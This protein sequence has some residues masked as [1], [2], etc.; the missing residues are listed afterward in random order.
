MS[1]SPVPLAALKR[2]MTLTVSRIV[3]V[4]EGRQEF[5]AQDEVA[6]TSGGAMSKRD[7]HVRPPYKD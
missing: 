6:I 3:G 5:D 7:P 1:E 2:A 4:P